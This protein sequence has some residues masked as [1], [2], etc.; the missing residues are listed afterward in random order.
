MP[1]TAAERADLHEG[2]VI[3]R[4]A[5]LPVDGLEDLRTLIRDRRPGDTVSILYLRA[6]EAH[7]TSATLGPSTD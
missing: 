7:T 3:V 2:D 6:G 1:G 4:F 5:G